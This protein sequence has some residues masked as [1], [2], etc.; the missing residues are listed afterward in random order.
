MVLYG[1]DGVI[2]LLFKD[3]LGAGFQAFALFGMK[4]G[5]KFISDLENLQKDGGGESIESLKQRMPPMQ[6]AT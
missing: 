6:Y 4:S 3:F 5:L 1:I 2:L